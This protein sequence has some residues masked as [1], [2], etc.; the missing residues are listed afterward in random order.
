MIYQTYGPGKVDTPAHRALALSAAEQGIVLL[1]NEGDLLPLKP[2]TNIAFIG[3]Q[4]NWT[5]PMLSDYEGQNK[6]V[7]EH[8]P[9][10]AAVRAGLRVTLQNG[11]SDDLN[12][13]DTS[14]IPAAVA[15]AKAA[16]VAIVF[17]GLCADHCPNHME[18]EGFD[19]CNNDG[20][21][22]PNRPTPHC[23]GAATMGLP[24]AQ[25]TLLEQVFAAQPNTVLVMQ[26]GGA[27][28]VDWAAA[29]VPAALWAGYPGELGGD[30]IVNTLTGHNNPAGKLDTTWYPAEFTKKRSFFDMDLRSGEGITHLWYSGT[31]LW[32]F[33]HGL[34]YTTFTYQWSSKEAA[35]R[36][37]AADALAAA[38]A[39]DYEVTVTN[40]GARAGDC[41]VLGFVSGTPPGF[42]RQKL[43]DFARVH[44]APGASTTVLLSSPAEALAVVDERGRRV[45]VP[46]AFEVRVGDLAAPAVRALEVAPAAAGVEVVLED[47][48]ALLM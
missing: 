5:L 31:P 36:S 18:D 8:S 16:D 12:S 28:A 33:G 4:A 41:V 46:G 1:K 43:F 7:L 21:Y 6:V 15:A 23:R 25:Q 20:H 29:N 35:A 2:G 11:T 3:P 32:A 37:I 9:Y 17:V 40:T 13:N 27:L 48:G 19:R 24:G 38:G 14:H 30:A 39:V 45:L 42:P 22:D 10:A 47:L 44:L 26:N 34:S